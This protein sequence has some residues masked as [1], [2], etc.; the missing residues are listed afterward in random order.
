MRSAEAYYH[1][2]RDKGEQGIRHRPVVVLPSL[3]H[4]ASTSYDPTPF[5]VKGKDLQPMVRVICSHWI[6][7]R[8]G[9]T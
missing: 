5:F 7:S 9:S 3:T 4:M 2:I 6:G 8:R 1:Q